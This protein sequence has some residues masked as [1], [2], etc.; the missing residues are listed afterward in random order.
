[1][2]GQGVS[3]NLSKADYDFGKYWSSW[4]KLKYYSNTLKYPFHEV[5]F[6]YLSIDPLFSYF[7]V[8]IEYG[9]YFIWLIF[10]SICINLADR[11]KN[12]LKLNLLVCN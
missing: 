4:L 7:R 10:H 5:S 6:V 2:Q 8:L 11:C 9:S 3:E 12:I 1:M